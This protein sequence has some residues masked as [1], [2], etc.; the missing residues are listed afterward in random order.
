MTCY[1]KLVT[2]CLKK[3]LLCFLKCSAQRRHCSMKMEMHKLNKKKQD[4]DFT[5]L[6]SIVN[7]QRE[8]F[9]QAE[10]SPDNFKCLTKDAE[11]KRKVLNKLEDEPK[12]TLQNLAEDCQRFINDRQDSAVN[13]VLHIKK[14]QENKVKK[15]VNNDVKVTNMD[16]SAICADP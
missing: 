12:L 7:D 1:Q 14:V 6:V 5:T 11:I 8:G 4:E 16:E 3:Q 9:K 15:K 13:S 2:K 10:L